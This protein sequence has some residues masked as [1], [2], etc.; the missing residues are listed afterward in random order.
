MNRYEEIERSIRFLRKTL[1][2]D[3]LKYYHYLSAGEDVSADRID[4][5]MT[6][7]LIGMGELFA[8]LSPEDQA[9]ANVYNEE[10]LELQNKIKEVYMEYLE[11]AKYGGG[12]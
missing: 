4:G 2:K 8:L 9:E 3:K 10:E 7:L 1:L 5:K 6:G 11:E 12:A